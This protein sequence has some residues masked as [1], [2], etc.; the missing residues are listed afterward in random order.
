MISDEKSILR[1]PSRRRVVRVLYHNAKQITTHSGGYLFGRGRRTRTL[2]NGFGDRYVTITSCPYSVCK[3]YHNTDA[4]K[5]QVFF[6]RSQEL[7]DI[8]AQ[9]FVGDTLDLGGGKSL[10]KER[11]E[12]RRK[13][14]RIFEVLRIALHAVKVRADADMT[15]ARDRNCVRDVPYDVPDHGM[16]GFR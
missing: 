6:V 16:P 8:V 4:G 9:V 5:M 11:V 3:R 1:R 2:K 15:D 13:V 10:R 12:Q 14:G 7:H